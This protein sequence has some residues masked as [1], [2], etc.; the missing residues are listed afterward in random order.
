MP[1]LG[2]RDD[3]GIAKETTRLTSA[4]GASKY[5]PYTD[6]DIQKKYDFFKDDS[7]SGR[8]EMLLDTNIAQEW[9]EGSIDGKLDPDTIGDFLFYFF[10]GDTPVTNLG[11]TT[12]V[13]SVA[14]TGQLPTFTT[15]Y[16]NSAMSWL[17]C[18]GTTINELE[19]SMDVGNDAGKYSAKT[20]GISE[21]TSTVQ[22]PSY[23]KP[24]KI[25]LPRHATAKFASTV[26]GL[27]AGTSIDIKSFKVSL[28]N[29][30][31]I[32]FDQGSVFGNDVYA[33]N[34]EGEVSISGVVKT[35]VFDALYRAGTPTALL[36]DVQNTQAPNLGTSTLKPAL[37]IEIPPS[38]LDVTYKKDIN[39]ITTFDAT[40]PLE[41]SV[42][43]AFVIRA[44]VQNTIAT[45]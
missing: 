4:G 7:A 39:G 29:N 33:K 34:F 21:T 23:T 13:F 31:E 41:F 1:F 26:A 36:I 2:R 44:T 45:Y 15:F 16:E 17:K 27:S 10:G 18:T 5:F 8:R 32:N 22:T 40:L 24:N 12:H 35:T 19:I 20:I 38:L 6:F 37:K 9:C 28:K 25:L 30:A 3:V 11:A 43:D 14:Q 42:V